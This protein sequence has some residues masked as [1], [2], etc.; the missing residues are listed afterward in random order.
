MFLRHDEMLSSKLPLLAQVELS[1]HSPKLQ[2]TIAAA[3]E[4]GL[5]EEEYAVIGTLCRSCIPRPYLLGSELKLFPL[6]FGFISS[7]VVEHARIL[8]S[9]LRRS[10]ASDCQDLFRADTN[11]NRRP[12]VL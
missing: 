5:S 2:Q 9:Y 12:S 1:R 7:G 8:L 10:D 4:G 6:V 11:L 3:C